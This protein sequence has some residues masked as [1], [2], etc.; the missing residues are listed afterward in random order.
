MPDLG[1]RTTVYYS[2][3]DDIRQPEALRFNT[4]GS[5]QILTVKASTNHISA[6]SAGE[7]LTPDAFSFTLTA[8]TV[9]ITDKTFT[10]WF[11]E[12]NVEDSLT[13]YVATSVTLAGTTFTLNFA[14]VPAGSYNLYLHIQDNGFFSWASGVNDFIVKYPADLT[15]SADLTTSFAGGKEITLTGKG[16]KGSG[17]TKVEVCGIEAQIKSVSSTELKFFAPPLISKEIDTQYTLPKNI[18][19]VSHRPETVVFSS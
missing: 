1:S 18:E 13:R 3:Q 19:K 17:V 16:F 7:F 10:A 11:E 4:T 6:K 2:I 14:D 12:K 5:W 15:A 8:G 9:T